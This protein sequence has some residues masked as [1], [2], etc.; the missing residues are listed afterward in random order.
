VNRRFYYWGEYE[1]EL[2]SIVMQPYDKSKVGRL[3]AWRGDHFVYNYD[4]DKVIKFSKFE[5]LLGKKYTEK[6]TQDYNICKQFFGKYVLDTEII[7]LPQNQRSIKI[8]PKI[9]GH[10][11]TKED[12]KDLS[13]A[14]QFDEIMASYRLL[15]QAG[16]AEIDLIGQE[17]FF[18]RSMGNIFIT[19][20]R[21]LFIIDAMLFDIQGFAIFRPF[22]SLIFMIGL[23][24]QKSIIKYFLNY[25]AKSNL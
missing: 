12:L 8:Q 4:Q 22:F 25:E 15:T 9:T 11:L 3:I 20:N 16:N 24:R 21:Q 1:N 23:W 17:G 14:R 10:H 2:I 6:T 18:K 5:F 19:P 7:V 13:I